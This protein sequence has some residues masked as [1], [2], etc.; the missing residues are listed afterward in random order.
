MLPMRIPRTTN[1]LN[2]SFADI[3]KNIVESIGGN[4]SNQLHYMAYINQPDSFFFRKIHCYSTEKLI[5]SL[6]NMS[7]N[8]NTIPVIF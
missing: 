5:C 1:M 4:D 6:K 7:R 2:V 8:L 3:G